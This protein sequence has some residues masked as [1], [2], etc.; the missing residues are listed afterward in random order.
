MAKS[1]TIIPIERIHRS[2]LL[3]RGHKVILDIDLAELYGVS[4]SYLNKA[5][6]RNITRFPEDFMFRLDRKEFVNLKFHLGTS[7]QKR[8]FKSQKEKGQI[9]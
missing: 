2:I 3:I 5:V 6:S 4:T 9:S 8:Y 1:D 7:T